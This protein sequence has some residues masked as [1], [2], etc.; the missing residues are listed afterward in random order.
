MRIVIDLQGAQTSGSRNRGIGRYSTAFA[1]AM[2]RNRREHDI[3]LALNGAFADT[4]D[5]IRTEFADL[6]PQAHIHVWREIGPVAFNDP[7]N[8]SRR[9]AAELAREAFLANLEPDFVHVTSHFEGL[10]DD[11]VTS[12]GLTGRKI[13]TSV[14]L[15]D[16]IPY[17]HRKPYLENSTVELWYEER[18]DHLRRADLLLAISESSRNEAVDY[19]NFPPEAAVEVGTAAD[20]QFVKTRYAPATLKQVHRRYGLTKPFVMYTGGI[21]YRKNIEALIRAYAM[22]PSAIRNEHQLA[23]VCSVQPAEKVRLLDLAG[24]SGLAEHEVIMTGFVPEEDL[25]ALYNSCKL[26]VFPSWHEGFGLPALEAMH[27]GAPVIGS[28]RSS[29]P[30]V[31]GLEEALFDPFDDGAIR[32]SIARGLT[33]E[34][35]RRRLVRNCEKQAKL[36]SWDK[37]ACVAIA[38]ME[39]VA[40]REEPV[41][42]QGRPTLAYVSPVPPARSGIADYSS[43][44]LPEL[45][46]HY[47]IDVIAKDQ[48]AADA[49]SDP[50]IKAN[51]RVRSFDEFLADY[52]GYDRVLYQVGNSDHHVHMIRNLPTHPG[53]VVLHDFFLSGAVHYIEHGDRVTDFWPLSLYK[54]HGYSAL[55]EH[56]ADPSQKMTTAKYPCSRIVTDEAYGVIVHSEYSLHLAEEW[57]GRGAAKSW[58]HIP[59]LRTPVRDVDRAAARE[60]LG[61]SSDELVVCS[62]GFLGPTKH[63]EKI[64]DTWINSPIGKNQKARLIFVG[65]NEGLEY[66]RLLAE[67]IADHPRI[68]ITGWTD[69]DQYRDY[70]A[71]ADVAVQLRT[72]SRGE[73]SGAVLDC[74]NYGIATIVN[75]NGSLASLPSDAVVLLPDAFDTQ[76]LAK[77]IDRLAKD[78]IVRRELAERAR[79][80]IQEA[81]SPRICADAYAE[82]IERGYQRALTKTRPLVGRINSLR[83]SGWSDEDRAQLAEALD[84][85]MHPEPNV[86]YVDLTSALETGGAANGKG[87]ALLAL[88]TTEAPTRVE[89]V[90]FDRDEKRWRYARRATTGLLNVSLPL[91]DE[92][93]TFASGSSILLLGRPASER[94]LALDDARV[95]SSARILF[96]AEKSEATGTG[97]KHPLAAVLEPHGLMLRPWRLN[98]APKPDPVD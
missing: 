35:F 45:A 51:L 43:E 8:H 80:H 63:S 5:P 64:A 93:V 37:A 53:V 46:R 26:F 85:A 77:A 82:A 11:A 22:L 66:G 6:L 2:I 98:D 58:T 20:P 19:L 29:L 12:V 48:S 7:A 73:T 92:P 54:A 18:L 83:P 13:R 14:S 31:I 74:M 67:K 52:D 40:A 94:A 71:S 96:A 34:K 38:A 59:H 78:E 42:I 9:R 32:D 72:L 84:V 90:Y 25:I 1:K 89:P 70:L 36:F 69:T 23:I 10:G 65:E 91:E 76:Q 86:T 88:V 4:L 57:I 79:A 47:E 61:I 28:N 81:R 49:V 68:S 87:D 44:L 16:L 15:Y 39:R 41:T 95:N 50:F 62:F 33:D 27:C 3:H 97:E 75:A 56:V 60:R 55:S 24:E 21:D 30:E 17:I